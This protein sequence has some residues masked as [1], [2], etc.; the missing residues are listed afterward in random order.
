MGKGEIVIFKPKDGKNILKV[1]LERETVWLTQAQMFKLFQKT[2]QNISLHINNIFKEGELNEI[3]V[4]KDSLTTAADGKKYRTKYYNLDVIISVGYRVKSKQGTQ[5]RI[6]ATQVLKDHIVKGYS[7]NEMRLKEQNERLVELQKTANLMGRLLENRNLKQ[8]ETAG[9][10]KVITDYSYA[11]TV[12]DQYDRKQLK[13]RSVTRK[14]EFAITYDKARLAIDKLGEQLRKKGGTLGLFGIE[15]DE[16]FKS[17]LG[18]IYQT[19]DGR[20]LYASVE[21]RVAHL[22]YFVI[23]NHS[24]VDGNKRIGA[25][26]FVWFLDVNSLLY[27]KNGQKR[28]GDN[29]LVALT[30]MIAESNPR[31]KDIIIR[32]I[33]NLINKKN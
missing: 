26:L 12:L 20:M 30:L 22:L 28:I 5:F 21:E 6:W 29:A 16:S 25:F 15:K 23:K 3:S 13:I 8:D 33:V 27:D 17:S 9:L 19:F 1:R 4:V 14:E 18:A 32:V 24:F 31:D 7:I 2:K 10:L 11:L